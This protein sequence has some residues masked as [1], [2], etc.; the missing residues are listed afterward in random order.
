MHQKWPSR[1]QKL[2]QSSVDI[3]EL[4]IVDEVDRGVWLAVLLKVVVVFIGVRLVFEFR[5]ILSC[6]DF[7][8]DFGRKLITRTVFEKSLFLAVEH[9]KEHFGST[10]L[11]YLHGL[12][13]ETSLSLAK[14]NVAVV[15]VLNV[16]H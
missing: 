16:V 2:F 9:Y 8:N 11:R 15:V 13:N 10:E 4:K 1:F 14:G 7:V 3:L 5:S 6:D 12:L